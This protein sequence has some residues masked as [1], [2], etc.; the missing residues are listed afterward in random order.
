MKNEGDDEKQKGVKGMIKK[1]K[2]KRE[3][4]K[5]SEGNNRK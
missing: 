3:K 5:G 4:Q 2:W 1:M